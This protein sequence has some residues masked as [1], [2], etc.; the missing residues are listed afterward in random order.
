VAITLCAGHGNPLRAWF[1][2]TD[3]TYLCL[4]FA[5]GSDALF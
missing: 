1:P 5:D 4:D 3:E 2:R